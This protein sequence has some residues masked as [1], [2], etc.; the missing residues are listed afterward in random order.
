MLDMYDEDTLYRFVDGECSPSEEL[1]VLQ[2]E[3]KDATLAKRIREMREANAMLRSAMDIELLADLRDDIVG[4][5]QTAH[6]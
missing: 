2:A 6:G 1:A 3:S 4:S 5:V